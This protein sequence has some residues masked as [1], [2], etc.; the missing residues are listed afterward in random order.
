MKWTISWCEHHHILWEMWYA[1]INDEESSD[2]LQCYA[3][4]QAPLWKSLGERSRDL[5]NQSVTTESF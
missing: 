2:G 4:K 5:F 1:D 3:L